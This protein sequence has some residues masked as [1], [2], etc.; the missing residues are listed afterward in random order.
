M[1]PNELWNK[2]WSIKA[3]PRFLHLLWRIVRNTIPSRRRLWNRG[4]HC[5]LWCPRCNNIEESVE[6]IFTG[7]WW[8]KQFWFLCSLG[9]TWDCPPQFSFSGWLC[10]MVM[11]A[12]MEVLTLV[13]AACYSIWKSRNKMCFEGVDGAVSIAVSKATQKA[14]A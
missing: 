5:P 4:I 3:P 10:D 8:S 6:H 7:C 1:V 14:N 2:L 11:Q 12:P 13:A 9:Y